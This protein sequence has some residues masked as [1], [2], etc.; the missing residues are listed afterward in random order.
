[1]CG[2]ASCVDFGGVTLVRVDLTGATVEPE[3]FTGGRYCIECVR[4]DGDVAPSSEGALRCL[5][6]WTPQAATAR[7]G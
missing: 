5:G 6:H 4:P 2:L 7:R 1:M 3:T